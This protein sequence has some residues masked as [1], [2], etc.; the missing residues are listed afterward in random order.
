[1]IPKSDDEERGP[2]SGSPRAAAVQSTPHAGVVP[3]EVDSETTSSPLKEPLR[4]LFLG[5]HA[6]NAE[7]HSRSKHWRGVLEKAFGE[8]IMMFFGDPPYDLP[9]SAYGSSYWVR[10]IKKRDDD[11][12]RLFRKQMLASLMLALSY[13]VR[14]R[15][16][17][18]VGLGEGSLIASLMARALLL[19]AACRARVA[20][21]RE[22]IDI[23]RAWAGVA[24]LI[25][26][27]RAV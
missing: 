21:A 20:T 18:I 12:R 16:Q 7:A 15:P 9:E 11:R 26:I 23:R 8:R 5:P 25:G 13:V 10:P 19:E 17:I 24:S 2:S 27:N 4:V 3:G 1:M 22:M 14:Y 6:G